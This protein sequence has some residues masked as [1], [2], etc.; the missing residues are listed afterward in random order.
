MI[1]SK[2][3]QRFALA[4]DVLALALL[5]AGTLAFFS[6]DLA[7]R[8][9]GLR[10]TV[11]TPWRPYL[12]AVVVLFVRNWLVRDPPSFPW[13]IAPFRKLTWRRLAADARAALPLDDRDLFFEMSRRPRQ[14]LVGL[15]WILGGYTAFFAVL[16][17]P[18]IRQLRSVPD[19]GDPLFSVWRIAWISHQLPRAPLALFDANQFYPDRLTLTYSDSMLVP[20]LMS[21]PLFWVGLHPI[22]AYN[23]L[24][25]SSFTLSAA[26]MFL[27][28]RALTGQR[29]PAAIG[30]TLFALYPYRFEHYSHLELLMTMWM[31][32]ALWGL[33]RTLALGRV[34]D[35]VLTGVAFAL[36]SLSSLYYGCFLAVYMAVLGGAIWLGRGRPRPPL[37]ALAAGAVIAAVLIAPVAAAYVASRPMMGTRDIGT[38]SFYS[39]KGPDYLQPHYRSRIYRPWSDGGQP[40]RELFP[41]VMPVVLAAAAIWPPLSIAR[42]A[43]LLA[44]VV[45]VDGSF[46][47]NG[48]TFTALRAALPPFQGLRVPARFSLFAGMSLT[49]LAAY[50]SARLLERWPLNR[51]GLAVDLLALVVVEGLPV[52]PLQRVWDAPPD[53]YGRIAGMEPPAVLAEFPMPADVYRSDFDARY[54]YFST[55]HWQ[56]LVNGNS[57]FFPPSYFDLLA[58]ERDFP[59]ESTLQYLRSRG[60]QY[61]AIHSRFTNPARYGETIEWLDARSDVELIAKAPWEGGE[62]RLY[63]LR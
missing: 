2:R 50:G 11:R 48:P 54:L 14:R 55:F 6:S 35:G 16:L 9:F 23:L 1:L 47:L 39:A 5:A 42:I 32:L 53:I 4:A 22:V 57:G 37:K 41:R 46:G 58:N 52:L 12:W 40:E 25:L 60:V 28:L 36:Q 19:L 7:F 51:V 24:V 44:F 29:V 59:N 38:I 17:W 18:Q 62:S 10:V 49:I 30:A 31:P 61:V 13:A 3:P 43:Y 27:L 45:A 8:A 21:A 26:A 34:R 33:H 63:R 15:A 20:G 56:S